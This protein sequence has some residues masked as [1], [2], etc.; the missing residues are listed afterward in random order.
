MQKYIKNLLLKIKCPFLFISLAITIALCWI[1]CSIYW[2]GFI[3]DDA[4]TTYLL[5]KSGWHP[6]IMADMVEMMYALFGYH[7]WT[8]FVLTMFPFYVGVWVI[9][10]AVYK[11]TKSW[12][13]LLFFFPCF[14]GNIFF[15][16]IKMGSSSFAAS[17]LFL[18]W[19]LTLYVVFNKVELKLL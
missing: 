9:V 17:Y 18:L 2:P 14:S 12:W 5:L 6:V 7:I 10:W 15:L 8:L 4:Q 16:L 1:H 3:Q 13:S 19:A 11:K